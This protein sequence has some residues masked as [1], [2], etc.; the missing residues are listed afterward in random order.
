MKTKEQEGSIWGQH[1]F[2]KKKLKWLVVIRVPVQSME[3]KV[4]RYL[5]I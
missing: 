5:D 3:L 2:R 4:D 1:I